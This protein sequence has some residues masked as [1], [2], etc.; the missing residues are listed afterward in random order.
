MLCRWGTDD[1]L[2][3]WLP[4]ILTEGVPTAAR[5]DVETRIS[6]NDDGG[7]HLASLVPEADRAR[8]R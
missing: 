8:T 6:R 1:D 7:A 5:E 4:A 2:R 3:I